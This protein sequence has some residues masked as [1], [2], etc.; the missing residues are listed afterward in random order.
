MA[1]QTTLIIGLG[2]IGSRIV[3]CIF[4]KFDSSN[5]SLNDRENVAFLCLDTD[6]ADI[7]K[8]KKVMPASSVIK[9]SSDLSDTVGGY[10]ARIKDSTTVEDWFDTSS[11]Q[12]LTMPLNEGAAQVRMASRL[13]AMSAIAEGKFKAIDN[14]ITQLLATDPERH[15]G[16]EIKV[17]IVTSLAGG[18]G[19]GSFLQVAYYV[20][21]ALRAKGHMAP[22]ISGYFVLADVLCDQINSSFSA[23]QREN[24]RSNTYACVKELL[25]F[26]NYNPKDLFKPIDFEYKLE[27]RDKSLPTEP[28]YDFCFMIDYTGTNGTNLTMAERY[29]EQVMMFV[30]S[31]AFDPLGDE[32]RSRA[33]NDVRQKIEQDGSNRFA[34]FGFSK[35]VYPVDDL[36]AYFARQRVY[37]HLSGTW[38][39]IDNEYFE[40][41]ADYK[42]KRSEGIPAEQPDRGRHYRNQIENLADNSTGRTRAEFRQVLN[43][44]MIEVATEGK[45]FMKPKS[46]VYLEAVEGFVCNIV[47]GNKELNDLYSECA[48]TNPTFSV[49]DNPSLDI[50]YVTHKER[51]LE[52][53][54][55]KVIE[56]IDN[57]KSFVIQECLTKDH[58]E[59]NYVSSLSEASHHLNTYILKKD[60][61]MHPLA[62]RYLLYDIQEQLKLVLSEKKASAG[63]LG[64]SI[65]ED[66]RKAFDNKETNDEI[67]DAEQAIQNAKDK[68]SGGKKLL[69]LISGRNPYKEA[70]KLYITKSKR[71]ASNIQKYSTEKLLEDTY[72]ALLNQINLLIEESEEFFK[73]IP[74]ITENLKEEIQGMLKKHDYSNDPAVSFVLAS[75]GIKKDI[76]DFVISMNDTAF[77][78]A[79]MAASLYRSMFHN[80]VEKLDNSGFKTSRKQTPKERQKAALEA[81]R[82]IFA[83][84]VS[85]QENLIRENN[86]EY[87]QKNVLAALKE[88]ALRECDNDSDKAHEYMLRK[89][90]A[91]RD[92]AVIWGPGN[93]DTSVRYINAWGLHP[94]C[95]EDMPEKDIDEIFGDTH[96]DTNETNAASRLTSEQFSPYEILR[97]NAVTLLTVEN[98]FTKFLFKPKTELEH[99]E[100][101]SYYQAYADVIGKI[102]KGGRTYSPHLDKHWHLPAYMP[103]IGE[104]NSDVVS[105]VFRA[106]YSGLLFGFFKSVN[107]GG[108]YYWKFIGRTSV[109]FLKDTDGEKIRLGNSLQYAFERLF[110]GLTNNPGIVDE[111]LS[112][113]EDKW[114][115]LLEDWRQR[116]VNEDNE[117]EKMKASKA[118]RI[119]DTFRFDLGKSFPNDRNWFSLLDSKQGMTLYRVLDNNEGALRNEFY[120]EII[121][122]MIAIF[123]QFSNTREVCEYIFRR[124]GARFK[125]EAGARIGLFDSKKMF[126]P[127]D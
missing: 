34:S 33:I 19:A 40:R 108:E 55:N 30:Y 24:V 51:D 96:V 77:F 32:F 126:Q 69:N 87:S 83:E 59:E 50:D 119:I 62:V 117:L 90:K 58:D 64:K 110:I 38:Q 45:P 114:E 9:T 44:T 35:L 93:L 94:D 121:N 57:T 99:E 89:F 127:N 111:I 113:S 16:N 74:A 25:T 5:P 97:V 107:Q 123:G 37:D 41:L 1:F 28:P 60:N 78:P 52:E 12:M 85:Y 36:M 68:N 54:K 66:Y 67:E 27:Q 112:A 7:A 86:T 115:E 48:A 17:H 39:R 100:I 22:K 15:P 98:N 120:D 3:E 46:Q 63:K 102:S 6:E 29:E 14:S 82:R 61:E 71:Q 124:A 13:A 43:E 125:E 122:R 10:I 72:A 11:N 49:K 26:S 65:F 88:E 95:L 47:E 116:E 105:R 8:R 42:K 91:F 20:K 21:D 31:N 76:Y 101:G 4:R 118:V 2:G 80:M 18:T 104:K 79:P 75:E 73:S 84:C 109:S 103:N 23:A 92:R 53:Y 81:N 56:F 70:K 106:L